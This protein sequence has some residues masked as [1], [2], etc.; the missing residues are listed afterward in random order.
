MTQLEVHPITLKENNEIEIK[1]NK[2]FLD[3]LWILISNPFV[4]LFTGKLRY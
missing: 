2:K 3:R 4:Y 1:T